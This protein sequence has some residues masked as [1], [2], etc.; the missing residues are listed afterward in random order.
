MNWLVWGKQQ[1]RLAISNNIGECRKPQTPTLLEKHTVV[2]VATSSSNT[3][4]VLDNGNIVNK[5]TNKTYTQATF[6][7]VEAGDKHFI[8]LSNDGLVFTWGSQTASCMGHTT[9]TIAEPKELTYFKDKKISKVYAGNYYC[10]CLS[11]ETGILY[12]FGHNGNGDLGNG[13]SST[14]KTPTKLHENVEK[15]WMGFCWNT[16][17]QYKDG[18]VK[19]FGY[20]GSGSLGTP[21][22]NVQTPLEMKF[23]FD[24]SKLKKIQTGYTFSAAL[25]TD[26]KVYGCGENT[27]VGTNSTYNSWKEIEF[28]KDIPIVDI[29]CG[30]YYTMF[31]G[32][33]GTIYEVGNCSGWGTGSKIKKL[34]FK[35]EDNYEKIYAG[36]NYNMF[37]KLVSKT[38]NS[39]LEKILESGDFT[40]LEICD[41]PVH[42]FWIETRLQKKMDQRIENF[43]SQFSKEDFKLILDWIYTEKVSQKEPLKSFFKEFSIDPKV[44]S[45]ENDLLKLY[46]DEDSKDFTILVPVE[47]DEDEDE[48]EEQDEEEQ[49][50]EVDEFLVHKFILQVSCGIYREMFKNV[51]SESKE[52]KDFSK[53]SPDS[54]EVFIKY[55]YT[56]EVEL[57]ADCIPELIVED[58][59]DAIDYFQLNPKSNINRQ[60]ENLKKQFD[61]N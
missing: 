53:K 30:Q 45:I 13:N 46:K 43:F 25:T 50:E 23:P 37:V 21:Q 5:H 14:V 7:Q 51:K 3:V 48:D 35:I 55:L 4:W 12:G 60:I 26:N 15:V 56:G 32:E 8:A 42:K 2:D 52:V 17:L 59:S 44:R 47:E 40:D 19:A 31:I 20:G 61:L 58:L 57:N 41:T 34:D 36:Y 18:K 38:F 11:E 39:D 29:A 27:K 33:D 1:N 22:T 16:F 54:F 24:N 49:E 28:F 9:N 10:M 6:V